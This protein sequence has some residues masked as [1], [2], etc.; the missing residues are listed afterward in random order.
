MEK[1]QE[2]RPEITAEQFFEEY[3]MR[4]DQGGR[5]TKP[6]T[7]EEII[8][9]L[10]KFARINWL[11]SENDRKIF[12]DSLTNPPAPNTKLKHVMRK[13]GRSKKKE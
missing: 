9:G 2:G 11:S 5:R 6:L 12:F 8:W 7:D 3:M 1:K 10:K 4:D 13:H